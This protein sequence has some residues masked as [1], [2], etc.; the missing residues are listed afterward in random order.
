M[1]PLRRPEIGSL[2]VKSFLAGVLEIQSMVFGVYRLH[3]LEGVMDF[4]DYKGRK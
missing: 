4:L 1:M 2:L 3:V